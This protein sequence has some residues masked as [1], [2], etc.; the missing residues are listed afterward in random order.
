MTLSIYLLILS[1]SVLIHVTPKCPLHH[2]CAVN[3]LACYQLVPCSLVWRLY[4]PKCET[5]PM[6][7]M[8]FLLYQARQKL[9]CFLSRS[10]YNDFWRIQIRHEACRNHSLHEAFTISSTFWTIVTNSTIGTRVLCYDGMVSNER[11]NRCA[12]F[13]FNYFA[14]R[15]GSLKCFYKS[16]EFAICQ[17]PRQHIRTHNN[18]CSAYEY[19][20]HFLSYLFHV[21]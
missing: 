9:T 12:H 21:I 11:S 13:S 16:S 20:N 1:R 17:Y 3:C 5:K 14:L 4:E 18:L 2:H 8:S 7:Y 10:I 6:Q 15:D 19:Q